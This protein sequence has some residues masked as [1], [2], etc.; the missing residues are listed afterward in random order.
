M[1]NSMASFL[2]GFIAAAVF[3]MGYGFGRLMERMNNK[4]A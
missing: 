1:S 3:W 2:A 4:K